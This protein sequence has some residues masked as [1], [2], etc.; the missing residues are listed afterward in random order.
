MDHPYRGP[1]AVG[2]ETP[3][4]FL[5]MQLQCRETMNCTGFMAIAGA[6]IHIRT[7]GCDSIW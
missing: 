3:C 5:T 4:D 6:L 2:A 1:C 7:Y